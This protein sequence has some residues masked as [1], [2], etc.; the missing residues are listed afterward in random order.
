MTNHLGKSSLRVEI[1]GVLL[2]MLGKAVDSVGKN[3]NLNL[4][5]TGISLI[6]FVLCDDG[7]FC[8]LGNHLFFTFLNIF[9]PMP[10]YSAGEKRRLRKD[11]YPNGARP[12]TIL[13]HRPFC[14]I[15]Y[16][17]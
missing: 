14:I 16:I 5:R 2:H 13:R 17:L 3:S 15:A 8:F 12:Y 7:G 11:F 10:R 6:D 4:G 1:L 9:T